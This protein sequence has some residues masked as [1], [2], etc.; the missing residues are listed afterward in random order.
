MLE[1]LQ[2]DFSFPKT[3]IGIVIPVFNEASGIESLSKELVDELSGYSFQILFVDDGS[4]D[5][6]WSK[7]KE[8]SR[9]SINVNG[10][11]LNKNL[12]QLKSILLG[13]LVIDT[14]WIGV[15]DGD[16]QNPPR[17]M[18]ELL[19]ARS[20]N[21][22]VTGVKR[23]RIS[24]FLRRAITEAFYFLISSIG[25]M[26]SLRNTGEFRVFHRKTL[27]IL[28][29]ILNSDSILR[30]TFARLG[31]K[32]IPILYDLPKR[33]SGK[34]KYT[35]LKRLK[36][37][38]DSTFQVYERPKQLLVLYFVF[39]IVTL[40]SSTLIIFFVW[41]IFGNGFSFLLL[42]IFV[43]HSILVISLL[44][45]VTNRYFHLFSGNQNRAELNRDLI[46]DS[47]ESVRD[48]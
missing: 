27:H 33:S 41:R 48:E 46:A 23:D 13:I 14:D 30:F 10:I 19:E 6:T 22:V 9:K 15:M 12:G 44:G 21:F 42:L 11:R 38:I 3:Q 25:K 24:N 37:V 7:I 16:G 40:T 4:S 17:V 5:E 34:T 32:E 31:V 20:E 8:M 28:L 18:R 35:L 47:T 36:L 29:P 2:H 1:S 45:I 26:T 39:S 43:A